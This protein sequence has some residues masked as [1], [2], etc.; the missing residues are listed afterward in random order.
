MLRVGQSVARARTICTESV[1]SLAALGNAK[2]EAGK[3]SEA[4]EHYGR[5]LA[6][7]RAASAIDTVVLSNNL[8]HA[9]SRQGEYAAAVPLFEVTHLRAESLLALPD[10]GTVRILTMHA[11]LT[12]P[13]IYHVYISIHTT[14]MR[15]TSL[16]ASSWARSPVSR[17]SRASS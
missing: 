13:S 15:R 17:A 14:H 9:L 6:R 1:V 4:S 2:L 12:A 3:F 7:C 5:A 8:A 10:C 11:P 16:R